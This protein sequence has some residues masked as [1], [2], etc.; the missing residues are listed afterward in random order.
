[1]NSVDLASITHI[2]VEA[3]VRYW[4]DATINDVVDS[5]G[6]LIPGRQGDTWH[7]RIHLATGK[8]ENWPQGVSGDLHYKVAD[9]GE[10]WLSN[11]E[12]KRLLKYKGSYVPDDYLSQGSQGFGDY[13]ILKVDQDGK[14]E[15]F[16]NPEID[17]E[18]WIEV[19]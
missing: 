18:R 16:R 11:A 17:I 5:E 19:S 14:I 1:M 3:N 12:G 6:T 9:A 10:Y 2:D 15:N 8:I 7:A 4:E 13:I